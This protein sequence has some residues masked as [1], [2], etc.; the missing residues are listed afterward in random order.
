MILYQTTFMDVCLWIRDIGKRKLQTC[1]QKQTAESIVGE[2]KKQWDPRELSLGN[3]SIAF[4]G[5]ATRYKKRMKEKFVAHLPYYL[6]F[7]I[8]PRWEQVQRDECIE[9]TFSREWNGY[10]VQAVLF[11]TRPE[12]SQLEHRNKKNEHRYLFCWWQQTEKSK[13]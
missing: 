2:Q 8:V 7:T 6:I 4:I 1:L 5:R 12:E 9:T 11:P 10:G 3:T 13:N